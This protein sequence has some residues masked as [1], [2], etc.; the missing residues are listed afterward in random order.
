MPDGAAPRC[1]LGCLTLIAVLGFPPG[2]DAG[3]AEVRVGNV[4]IDCAA[5]PF[6]VARGVE[7]CRRYLDTMTGPTYR[8]LSPSDD[9]FVAL[10]NGMVVRCSDLGEAAHQLSECAHWGSAQHSPCDNDN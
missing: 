7:P 9:Q 10:A 1:A 3:H 4:I 6:E 2:A 5:L 8:D